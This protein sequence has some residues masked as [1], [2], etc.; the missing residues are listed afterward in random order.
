MQVFYMLGTT[1][2]SSRACQPKFSLTVLDLQLPNS[3]TV[4]P[5]ILYYNQ[6]ILYLYIMY[7]YMN[8]FPFYI[9]T[10]YSL[11][12]FIVLKKSCL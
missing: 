9:T 2:Y 11:F 3:L 8:V 10:L 5:M 6:E 4:V 12:S 7:I 1:L